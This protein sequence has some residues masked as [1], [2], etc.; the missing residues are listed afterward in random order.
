MEMGSLRNVST[1]KIWALGG[2]LLDT[3]GRK[4]EFLEGAKERGT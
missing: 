1:T 4:G 3:P 2:R